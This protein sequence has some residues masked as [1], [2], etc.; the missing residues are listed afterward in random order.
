M[1]FVVF[2]QH[3]EEAGAQREGLK[4]ML[5]EVEFFFFSYFVACSWSILFLCKK[6]SFTFAFKYKSC[7]SRLSSSLVQISSFKANLRSSLNLSISDQ[8]YKSNNKTCSTSILLPT[9]LCLLQVSIF[10][11][12]MLLSTDDYAKNAMSILRL[13]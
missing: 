13:L 5:E 6:N 9:T 3:G 2:V 10:G 7:P 8:C 4:T 12:A 1:Q 11:G